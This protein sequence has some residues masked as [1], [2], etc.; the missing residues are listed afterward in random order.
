MY[1]S[2][3]II[4]LSISLTAAW[5]EI[6]K[7]K[8]HIKEDQAKYLRRRSVKYFD[9]PE[10]GYSVEGSDNLGELTCP[11]CE[12]DF[13]PDLELMDDVISILKEGIDK[14]EM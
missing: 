3:A 13:Y 9:C 11:K 1:N 14:D 4:I 2:I 5:L 6:Y 10:C 7:L 8:A 12:T